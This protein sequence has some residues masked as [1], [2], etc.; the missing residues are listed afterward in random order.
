METED[1]GPYKHFSKEL[2]RR[3]RNPLSD[4][5]FIFYVV[6]GVLVFGGLGVWIEVVKVYLPGN[7]RTRRVSEPRSRF[8]T[9][10]SL[11][12]HHCS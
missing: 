3:T 12:P 6:F 11:E 4:A 9:L 2:K 7:R 1:D 5:T 10:H 8:S